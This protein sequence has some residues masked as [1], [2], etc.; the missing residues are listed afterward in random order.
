MALIIQ[1]ALGILLGFLLIEYRHK[2]GRW[3]LLGLKII[4]GAVVGVA[5]VSAL[6]YLPAAAGTAVSDPPDWLIRIGRVVK[7]AI[8]AMPIMVIGLFGAYGLF[9]LARRILSRW[10][11][12]WP[13]AGVILGFLFLNMLIIWPIDVY[14]RHYT[15]LGTVYRTLGRWSWENGYQDLFG[16][17]LSF[18]LGLWPWVIIW[19]FTRL[20]VDFFPKHVPPALRHGVEHSEE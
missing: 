11:T 3:A 6:S 17:L 8:A 1:I 18:S 20:G 4:F 10:F 5:V 12:L 7:T 9:A 19:V 2:L 13:T 14:L 15:T 16:G